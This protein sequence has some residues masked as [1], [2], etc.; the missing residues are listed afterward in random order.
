MSMYMFIAIDMYILI[1]GTKKAGTL[2]KESCLIRTI[3]DLLLNKL[4][5]A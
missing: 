4:Y 5:I 1:L 2:G 3:L